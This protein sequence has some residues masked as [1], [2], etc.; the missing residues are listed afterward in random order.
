MICVKIDSYGS[1]QILP[2]IVAAKLRGA[3]TTERM[4]GQISF[5]I[6]HFLTLRIKSVEI[7]SGSRAS[8]NALYH[9]FN[10]VPI[11]SIHT[12]DFRV[13]IILDFLKHLPFFFTPN[14]G[15]GNANAAEAT[16]TPDAV[17]IRLCVSDTFSSVWSVDFRDV[18]FLIFGCT[19]SCGCC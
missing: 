3:R 9:L 7:R 5:S 1:I 2:G 10:L 14:E 12:L 13:E 15:H 17:Q 4:V 18:L 16:G 6:A 11:F 19:I 8:D